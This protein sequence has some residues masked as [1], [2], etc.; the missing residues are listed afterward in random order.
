MKLETYHICEQQGSL[1][2]FPWSIVGIINSG[3][4]AFD[5]YKSERRIVKTPTCLIN[6]DL[7]FLMNNPSNRPYT[8]PSLRP[9]DE[10]SFID[11]RPRI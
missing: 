9:I 1:T 7:A 10:A 5:E 11:S 8:H 3:N 4:T 6:E 2:L